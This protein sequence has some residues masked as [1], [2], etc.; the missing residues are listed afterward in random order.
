M[1]AKAGNAQQD[2]ARRRAITCKP[3]RKGTGSRAESPSRP[4]HASECPDGLNH[5]V[6][7]LVNTV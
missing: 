2:A 1:A 4:T 3:S 6:A 7:L 5:I